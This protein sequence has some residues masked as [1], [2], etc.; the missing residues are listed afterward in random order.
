MR[1]P[2]VNAFFRLWIGGF[3]KPLA[4]MFLCLALIGGGTTAWA[5]AIAQTTITYASIAA[6]AIGVFNARPRQVG[7]ARS[8]Q[9]G[10]IWRD[11]DNGQTLI[12]HS[13]G[14]W[15]LVPSRRS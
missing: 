14:S 6:A 5:T 3:R 8:A 11:Y 4:A 1:A 2:S 13:N 15:D 12:T 9:D 10:T 7:S